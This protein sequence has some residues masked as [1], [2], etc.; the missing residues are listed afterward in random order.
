VASIILKVFSLANGDGAISYLKVW[1]V[2]F[3]ENRVVQ[4][5]LGSQLFLGQHSAEILF[6]L[7]SNPTL[8][9]LLP[10]EH[11]VND[12]NDDEA[13][14]CLINWSRHSFTPDLCDVFPIFL[15]T[16]ATELP[17]AP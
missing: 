13:P 14:G 7:L 2:K 9:R 11:G 15:H 12:K 17:N 10:L 8:Y 16:R 5:F 1:L 3:S 6:E 4:A